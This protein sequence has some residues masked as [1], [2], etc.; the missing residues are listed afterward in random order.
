MFVSRKKWQ[1]AIRPLAHDTNE[2]ASNLSLFNVSEP[3]LLHMA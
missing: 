3:Q 1:S 2:L